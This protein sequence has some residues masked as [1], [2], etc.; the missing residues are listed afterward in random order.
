MI[1]RADFGWVIF[2]AFLFWIFRVLQAGARTSGRGKAPPP[3]MPSGPPRGTQREGSELE[4]LFRQLQG[5]LG[6]RSGGKVEARS[7]IVVKRQAPARPAPV[8][9]VPTGET[10]VSLEEGFD[11]EGDAEAPERTRLAAAT[12][13]GSAPPPPSQAAVSGLTSRQLRDAVV[14]QEILG[15]PKGLQ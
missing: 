15:P 14:W 6:G 2:V 5:R 8:K 11:Q 13:R 10:A 4:E 3:P 1:L 7:K 12:A 9:P